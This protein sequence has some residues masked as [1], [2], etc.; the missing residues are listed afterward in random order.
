MESDDSVFVMEPRGT[1]VPE[2][3]VGSGTSSGGPDVRKRIAEDDV[4]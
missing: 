2:I 4:V 1:M 3:A